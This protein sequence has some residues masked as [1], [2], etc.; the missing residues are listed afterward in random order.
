MMAIVK[1]ETLMLNLPKAPQPPL[2]RRPSCAEGVVLRRYEAASKACPK[3]AEGG[4][5]PAL[6]LRLV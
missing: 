1:A 4:A 2:A 5:P 6:D 3:L